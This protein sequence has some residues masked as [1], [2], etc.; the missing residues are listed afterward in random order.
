M[1]EPPFII[2]DSRRPLPNDLAEHVGELVSAGRRT[3]AVKLF[4]TNGMGIPSLLVTLMRLLMPGWSK[5]TSI[6][7]TLP[8]DLAL[9]KGLQTGASLPGRR[10]A[11]TN[12]PTMVAVGSKSEPFFHNGAKALARLLPH[13]HYR[14]LEGRNH[15]AV[16][17]AP[18]AIAAAVS[19]FI[20]GPEGPRSGGTGT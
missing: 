13:G 10:W 12:A 18:K 11:S 2:D 4:L 5:M 1:Y 14:S 17:M 20:R 16:M 8:Y 19:E 7:H 3:D 6:A 15:A 9:L